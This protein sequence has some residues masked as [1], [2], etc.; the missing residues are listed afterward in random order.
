VDPLFVSFSA[1]HPPFRISMMCF[2]TDAKMW[3]LKFGS[4]V[5]K[6]KMP[7]GSEKP[8]TMTEDHPT[9]KSAVFTKPHME[10]VNCPEQIPR[11][12]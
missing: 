8:L 10:P 9:Y 12:S 6:R 4:L 11:T 7:G 2:V 3:H 5:T 1:A